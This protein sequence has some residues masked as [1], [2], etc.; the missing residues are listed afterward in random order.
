M[1]YNLVTG[2]KMRHDLYAEKKSTDTLVNGGKKMIVSVY[3]I[4]SFM[5]K[6]GMHYLL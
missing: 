3:I 2:N 1:S 4:L 6:E 5:H